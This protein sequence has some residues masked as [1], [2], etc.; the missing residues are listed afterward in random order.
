MTEITSWIR[1]QNQT[2]FILFTERFRI[3]QGFMSWDSTRL[4]TQIIETKI[5]HRDFKKIQ[6]MYSVYFFGGMLIWRGGL[7]CTF[8]WEQKN[9]Q[10]TGMWNNVGC[11]MFWERLTPSS[12]DGNVGTPSSTPSLIWHTSPTRLLYTMAHKVWG[13]T[14]FCQQFS[15]FWKMHQETA[16]LYFLSAFPLQR[17]FPRYET[18]EV[19]V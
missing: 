11:A 5:S 13:N 7:G 6:A 15:T 18:P 9:E 8:N 14:Y 19:L 10:N 1:Y 2:Y 17:W 12:V 16:R 4:K 3:S